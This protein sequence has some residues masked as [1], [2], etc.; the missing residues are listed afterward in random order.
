MD[1]NLIILRCLW[2]SYTQIYQNNFYYYYCSYTYQLKA[3]SRNI[4]QSKLWSWAFVLRI[5]FSSVQFSL[6]VLSDSLCPHESQHARLPCP[7]PTPR[8]YPNSCTLSWWCQIT[9]SS[10]V[11][12]FSSYLQSFPTL[13]SFPVSQPKILEFELQHQSFQWTPRTDFL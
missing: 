3:P 7:S 6:S 8:V 4:C 13:G 11:I 10:S 12:P 1:Q 2:M 9:I 5:Q